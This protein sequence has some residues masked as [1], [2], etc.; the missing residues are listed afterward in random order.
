MQMDSGVSPEIL[1][2]LE[3]AID[4]MGEA[5]DSLNAV[6]PDE[7]IPPEQEAPELLNKVS[8]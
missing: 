5:S 4:R 3:D 7:A 1:M 8:P 6:R 2:N